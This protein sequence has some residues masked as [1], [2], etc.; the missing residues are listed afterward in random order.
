MLIKSPI[1]YF[2]GKSYIAKDIV[3]LF[4][5]KYEYSYSNYV[6]PFC[7]G[8]SV[9]FAAT[10]R[11]KNLGC[12]TGVSEVLND[13]YEVLINFFKV[14]QDMRLFSE[15]YRIITLQ[16]FSEKS[17]EEACSYLDNIGQSDISDINEKD[18]LRESIAFFICNRLSWAGRMRD[19]AAIS[20]AKNRTRTGRNEQVN[21][22]LGCIDKL[23]KIVLRLQDAI[24]LNRDA[25]SVIRE[26]DTNHT[27]FY[28]DPPY[29]LDT[30]TNKNGS[31]Y[32]YEMSYEQHE[33]LLSVLA[34][35]KFKSKF[36]LSCYDSKL[37]KDY[38]HDYRWKRYEFDTIE[39]SSGANS[40]RKEVLYVNY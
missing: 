36:I 14:L 40:E 27:L 19:F 16:P 23:P 1:K 11:H 5:N 35:D 17:F 8:A 34:N 32:I 33:E 2:G 30:R 39:R 6:E 29:L 37:Y 20:K 31:E 24:I 21:S 13:K 38:A 10:E 9:F 26:F 15:F 3:N 25:I 7:G 18:M 22:W 12:R 4:P 28:L